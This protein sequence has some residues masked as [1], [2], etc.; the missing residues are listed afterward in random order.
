M[1]ASW[2]RAPARWVRTR[3][4]RGRWGARGLVLAYHRVAPAERDPFDLCVQPRHFAEHVEALGR[5]FRILPLRELTAALQRERGEFVC[6]SFDDGYADNLLRAKPVLERFDVPATVFVT[7][8]AERARSEFWWDRLARLLLAAEADP[9]TALLAELGVPLPAACGRAARYAVVRRV[10]ARLCERA[11]HERQDWLERLWATMPEPADRADARLLDADGI[12][13]L[14]R[15]GLVEIGAHTVSHPLLDQHDRAEQRIEIEQSK[16]QLEALLDQPVG[17]FAYPHGRYDLGARD[18][19]AGAGFEVA[20]T[21][22]PGSVARDADPLQLPRVLVR[23]QDGDALVDRVRNW[24]GRAPNR[25][26][27]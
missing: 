11:P 14:A 21:V 2:T 13:T 26:S 23:D 1:A 12:R 19:V 4:Q 27:V 9:P 18:L 6:L 17:S 5:R 16:R 3:W 8:D 22:A 10:H 7:S 15:G 24:F 25:V 20:C